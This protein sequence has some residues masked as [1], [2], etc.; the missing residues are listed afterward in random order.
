MLLLVISED[1]LQ[2]FLFTLLDFGLL[3]VQDDLLLDLF[4][5]RG[6]LLGHLIFNGVLLRL[7]LVDLFIHQLA[8]LINLLNQSF[9]L[10]TQLGIL[11]GDIAALFLS[12]AL[13][14]LADLLANLTQMRLEVGDDVLSLDLFSCD[15]SLMVLFECLVLVLVLTS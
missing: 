6:D 7:L 14:V 9:I 15:D 5:L 8:L 12:E 4:L 13:A 10:S 2:L 3:D 1:F 11:T